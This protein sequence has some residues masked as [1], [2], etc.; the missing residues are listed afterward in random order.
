MRAVRTDQEWEG[1]VKVIIRAELAR[2]Q[3][4][5]SDLAQRLSAIGVK[6]TARN[7]SNKINRGK[8]TAV[9]FFQCMESTTGSG[10]IT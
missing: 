9:Y 10:A 8:F 4:S 3:L 2:R 6:E 7:I 5:Y 1:V